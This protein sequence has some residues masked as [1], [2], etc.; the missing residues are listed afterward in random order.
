MFFV[1]YE[2][3]RIQDD[4][5]VFKRNI[6]DQCMYIFLYISQQLPWPFNQLSVERRNIIFAVFSCI[7]IFTFTLGISRLVRPR[8]HL[9]KLFEVILSF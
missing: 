5:Y 8:H 2:N 3:N 4:K 7:P 6:G 9:L 1:I